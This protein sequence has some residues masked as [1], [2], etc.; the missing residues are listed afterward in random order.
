MTPQSV[1]LITRHLASP[2]NK[3]HVHLQVPPHCHYLLHVLDNSAG[4]ATIKLEIQ[5]MLPP[6]FVHFRENS[7]PIPP[8]S[9]YPPSAG[10]AF[11]YEDGGSEIKQH[12]QGPTEDK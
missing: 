1:C 7:A 6:T 4:R 8:H 3:K 9:L 12:M 2:M 10:P 5:D 11:A